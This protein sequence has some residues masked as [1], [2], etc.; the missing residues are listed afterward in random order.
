MPG[1]GEEAKTLTEGTDYTVTYS[2][3]V[4]NAGTVTVTITGAGNYT[5]EITKTYEIAPRT[6]NLVSEGGTK[7]YDGTP[8]T[9]P[10][11]TGW[12]Q[13][14]DTGF[15]TG[16]VSDVKATGSVTTVDEGEVPNTITYTEGDKFKV[17]NYDINKD[18]G[19]LKITSADISDDKFFTVSQP[20]DVIYNGQEQKQPVTVMTVPGEGEEAKT[21][22]E[23][24][25][26]TVTYS[27][28]VTNA[29]T[30]TVTIT[31][32]GN[33]TGTVT[34]TYNILPAPVSLTA[35]S[36]TETYSGNEQTVSGFTSSVNGLT[37]DGVTASGRGTDA[38]NYPVTFTGVTVG[39]TK[40]KTG[41]Y[42]VTLATPGALAITPA[43]LTVTTGSG[44][45]AYDGTALTNTTA[46]VT[47]LV[48]NETV[49][50]V[51][52]GSQ[53]AVGSSQNTYRIT[54]NGTA[55]E[56]NYKIVREN[57]GTLTVT[58][59]TAP[60]PTP[61]PT[62]TPDDGDDTTDGGTPTAA[63]A[64]APAPAVAPPAPAVVDDTPVPETAPPTDIDDTPAPQ[65]APENPWA[66]INLI[67]AALATVGA[68]IALFRRKEDEED[69]DEN[70]KKNEDE[71]EDDNRTRKMNIAKALGVLAAIASIVAF[72]LTEDMSGPMQL[73]D[74]WTILMAA[75]FAV[76]IGTAVA[77]K[78]AAEAEEDEEE[79]GAEA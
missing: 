31:G 79:E 35:N 54:W 57:L 8:L 58:Q 37:F 29:G 66:L 7:P 51:A 4:T 10:T 12:E 61:T 13:S 40:D 53:T 42:V 30:V 22:T 15:I 46:T 28:D 33:Y 6:V 1:E 60:T 18:E 27:D 72:I 63:P 3:D 34:R 26:Y 56:T 11:V 2:D 76:Q 16:E 43:E 67:C 73:V 39:E 44:S 74:Q 32:I 9:K 41:N 52:T 25:D 38:G 55:K 47:G 17:T 24:T 19:T 23:G 48:N 78:K 64:A 50:A 5:G 68:I 71:E 70:K 77:V 75:L 14:G 49:T 20:K 21:L 65:A 69:E 59:A 45:K 36:G 62:P